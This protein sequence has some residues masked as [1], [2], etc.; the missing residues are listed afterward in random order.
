MKITK[1]E[2]FMLGG[3]AGTWRGFWGMEACGV[4]YLYR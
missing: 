4:P 2:V 1:A 3:R